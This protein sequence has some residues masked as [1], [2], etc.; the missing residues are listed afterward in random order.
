MIADDGD[1]S[2]SGQEDDEAGPY[3][4]AAFQSLCAYSQAVAFQ[5]QQAALAI[6]S[7]TISERLDE[8]NRGDEGAPSH[9]IPPPPPHIPSPALAHFIIC[10]EPS[11]LKPSCY[12]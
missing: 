3:S 2:D 8:P 4:S 12:A 5:V 6:D 9:F 7:E 1:S 11:G 10:I